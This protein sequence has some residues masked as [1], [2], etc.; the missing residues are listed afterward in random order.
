M[1]RDELVSL[2]EELGERSYRAKQLAEAVYRQR[3]ELIEEISTLSQQLRSDLSK[4]NIGIG[5]PKI[6]QRFVSEDGTVRYLIGLADGQSV[7]TVWMPEG[8][9]GEAGDGSGAGVTGR[10]VKEPQ[11]SQPD[12]PNGSRKRIRDQGRGKT[13]ARSTIC[14][15]SQ[16]GCAVDLPCLCP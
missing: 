9:G 2:V 15:S 1:E 16:V 14:I 5:M 3:V 12:E 13:W 4:K 7:E 10:T 8:D 6:E 11:H